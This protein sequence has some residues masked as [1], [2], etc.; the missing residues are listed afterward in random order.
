MASYVVKQ[1][2]SAVS[3]VVL[4]ILLGS[5][6]QEHPGLVAPKTAQNKGNCMRGDKVGSYWVRVSIS[7]HC[8]WFGNTFSST[9]CNICIRNNTV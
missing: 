5:N 3:F 9:W 1:P 6:W 2:A 4:D 7:L 8:T